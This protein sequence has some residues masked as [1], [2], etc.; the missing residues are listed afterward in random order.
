P[1]VPAPLH[2]LV[3]YDAGDGAVGHAVAGVTSSNP[4]GLIGTGIFSDVGH[5]VT[6]LH[7]LASPSIVDALEHRKALTRPL[8]Q[9]DEPF[10]GVFGPTGLMVFAADD[11]HLVIELASGLVF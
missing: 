5:V 4:D 1:L 10:V 7:Y 2:Q 11:Q 3:E 8:L 6:G 9:V